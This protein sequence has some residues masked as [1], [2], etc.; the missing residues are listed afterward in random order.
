MLIML[1]LKKQSIA[2]K[3]LTFTVSNTILIGIILMGSGY[4]LQSSILK[5]SFLNQATQIT[6][7]WAKQIDINDVE[8]AKKA[9]SYDDSSQKNLLN[10][11]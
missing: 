4:F 11:W 5:K 6:Q 2:K 7:E 3:I 1:N 10:I 9:K 8:N